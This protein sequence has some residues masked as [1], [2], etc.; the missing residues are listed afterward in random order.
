MEHAVALQLVIALAVG[1]A[2]VAL[3]QQFR[4][5]PILGY[6]ATG[7][8]VG[9]FALGWLQDGPTMRVLAESGVVLLMFTIGLAFSLPRLLSA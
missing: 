3:C 7:V 4:L 8:L 6:L 2:M 5:S 1:T 9:P